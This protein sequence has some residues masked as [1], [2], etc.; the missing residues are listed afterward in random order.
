MGGRCTSVRRRTTLRENL[1]I[2][3]MSRRIHG[4]LR[5]CGCFVKRLRMIPMPGAH[6]GRHFA[7]PLIEPIGPRA[8]IGKRPSMW[9]RCR[10]VLQIEGWK[11]DGWTPPFRILQKASEG[12]AKRLT[13]RSLCGGEHLL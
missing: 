11:K 2:L 13:G 9:R 8:L 7:F 6:P 3:F 5:M 10:S 12:H 1:F 4:G